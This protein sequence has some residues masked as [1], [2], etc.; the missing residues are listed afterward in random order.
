MM[1]YLNANYLTLEQLADKTNIAIKNIENLIKY[2][3]IPK[4][5]HRVI[6]QT[7]FE[8]A[9]FDNTVIIDGEKL[10]YHPSLIN[11]IITAEEYRKNMDFAKTA[12]KIKSDFT[13]ELHKALINAD[14]KKYIANINIEE[15]IQKQWLDVMSGS[16]GVCLKEI[17]VKNIVDKAIA[18]SVLEKWLE[19]EKPK[20]N[21]EQHRDILDMAK[22][23]DQIS[24]DFGPHEISKSTR[25]RLYDVFMNT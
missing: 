18:V 23:Y 6:C 15:Y 10:Y 17:S 8:T 16:Y 19:A 12:E 4:H 1:T 21:E 9:V 14:I 25:G 20:L 3:C 5:S 24:A 22:L 13:L 11:W 7:V 2:N